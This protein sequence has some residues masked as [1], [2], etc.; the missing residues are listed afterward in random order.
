M[1][2][3]III[4]F[5]FCLTLVFGQK[6]SDY[7]YIS[8]PGKFK[9]FEEE[10]YGLDGALVKALQSRKYIVIQGDKE[11]WPSDIKGKSCNVI[12]ANLKND[13]NFLRNKLLLEFKDCNDKVVFTTK[14]GSNIKEYKEGFQDALKQALVSVPA[15]NPTEIQAVANNSTEQPKNENVASSPVAENK[16]GKYTNGKMSL[17]KIQIDANQFILADPNSSVPYATFKFT[18][19]KDVF[20]VKMADGSFTIGYMENGDIVI[21]IPQTNGEYSK[22]IFS[23]K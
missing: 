18:S 8:I 10:S 3:L 16:T 9:D 1:K 21:D 17:Q 4:L 15:S 11:Q 14:G 22:E 2:K 23:G 12:I 7:K 19:K 6:I 5:C 20:R 13:S